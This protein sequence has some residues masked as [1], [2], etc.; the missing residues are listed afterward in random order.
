MSAAELSTRFRSYRRYPVSMNSQTEKLSL[1]GAA[2][3]IEV[4][5]DQPA[6][7]RAASR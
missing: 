5:R 1:Q 2:G 3:A 6:A 7:R 4:Q